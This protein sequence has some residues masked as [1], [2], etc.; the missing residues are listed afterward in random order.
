[1]LTARGVDRKG[2]EARA[3][4]SDEANLTASADSFDNP[5]IVDV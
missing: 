2:P 3:E 1:L 5:S 4:R